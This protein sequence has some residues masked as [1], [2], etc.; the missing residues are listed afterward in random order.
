L[1]WLIPLLI[2]Y[3]WNLLNWSNKRL[4]RSLQHFPGSCIRPIWVLIG[5]RI[6][7]WLLNK[8]R[9]LF[10]HYYMFSQVCS[11]NRIFL[12]FMLLIMI[13]LWLYQCGF[14]LINGTRVHSMIY[15]YLKVVFSDG[16]LP[17][18]LQ[19]IFNDYVIMITLGIFE[20]EYDY[21]RIQSTTQWILLFIFKNVLIKGKMFIKLN[22]I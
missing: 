16:N 7:K 2:C 5:L 4:L 18:W 12:G 10:N 15:W 11:I 8:Y 21:N 14:S 3:I 1:R 19:F 6:I 13:F 9:S 17:V 22:K 20:V